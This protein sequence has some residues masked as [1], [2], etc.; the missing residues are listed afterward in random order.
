[1]SILSWLPAVNATLNATSALC[2]LSGYGFIRR[3][4]IGAHRVCMLAACAVSTLF[5]VSYLTYHAHVGSVHFHGQGWIRPVY[6]A[7]LIS[8]TVLAI[9]IVPL[10][11]RTLSLALAQRFAQHQRLARLTLPLWLYVSVTGVIVYLMLYQWWP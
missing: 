6:F 4:R 1:M 8:H 11:I 9:V 5:L 10:V 7:I 2:L 3:K